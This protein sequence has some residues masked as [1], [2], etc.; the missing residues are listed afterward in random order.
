MRLLF[1]GRTPIQPECEEKA[2]AF[3]QA[4]HSMDHRGSFRGERK[5]PRGLDVVSSRGLC[6]EIS[7]ISRAILRGLSR[8]GE[9][10]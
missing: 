8:D 4:H 2:A 5:Q 3:Q 1:N 10:K 6:I 7:L 9:I